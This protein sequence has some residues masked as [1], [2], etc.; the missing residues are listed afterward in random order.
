MSYNIN[1]VEYW[2]GRFATGDWEA[3]HGRWQTRSF[4][5]KQTTLLRLPKTFDGSLLD[6][7]CGLG[8]AFPVYRKRFP[9]ADLFGCDHSR[10]AIELCR[11]EYG[12]M[13]EFI[14]GDH[15]SIPSVD[16]IIA[17]NV[18]EHISNDQLISGKLLLRCSELY[19]FVPNMGSLLF[20]EHVNS[21]NK[22]SFSALAVRETKVFLCRGYS[23]YGRALW[24]GVYL[25]NLLR[26]FFGKP[27]CRRSK[28]IMFRLEGQRG[29]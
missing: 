26:P 21:Y 18:L 14:H 24:G 23:Q 6:F 10:K 2:D 4:A 16:V 22:D 12:N 7:G 17:S 8:D 28:Q 1:T 27:L 25:K 29:R 15:D 5:E 3:K 20:E 19:V 9:R 11:E 13:A